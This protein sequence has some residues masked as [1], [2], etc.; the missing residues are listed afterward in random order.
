MPRLIG[1]QSNS[2]QYVGALLI[3]AIATAGCVEYFGV[4]DFVPNFGK[5]G[6]YISNAQNVS[7]R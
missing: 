3:V 2:G 5:S 7:H 1:K 4:I 6:A